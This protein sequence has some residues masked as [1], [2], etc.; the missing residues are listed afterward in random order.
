MRMSACLPTCR[1]GKG[2]GVGLFR[3]AEAAFPRWWLCATIKIELKNHRKE[4][5][6]FSGTYEP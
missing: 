5:S 3:E 2:R 6:L 1:R 4:P